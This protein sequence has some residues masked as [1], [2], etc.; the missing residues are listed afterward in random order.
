MVVSLSQ[1]RLS[2][3]AATS[4]FLLE[5]YKSSFVEWFAPTCMLSPLSNKPVFI[6]FFL[7]SPLFCFHNIVS[8][9]KYTN[10]FLLYAC[11]CKRWF[12][13]E[14]LTPTTQDFHMILSTYK[15][16]A[17]SCFVDVLAKN[18]GRSGGPKG[19]T[20]HKHHTTI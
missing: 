15:R 13:L 12:V 10:K 6:F 8:M 5:H 20:I 16:G 4:L 19:R 17:R 14:G 11:I 2:L 1:E 18:S 3:K 9:I 7:C